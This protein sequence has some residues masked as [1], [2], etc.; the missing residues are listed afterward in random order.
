MSAIAT[1]AA[2]ARD[3]D[4]LI[5]DWRV[6]H[7]RLRKRLAGCEDW[8]A[9]DGTASTRLMLD[10]TGN[11]EEHALA[12]PD[13][14]Y[15][16]LALRAFDA[17]SGLWSIWWLDARHPDRLDPPVVGR[18]ENTTGTFYGDDVFEA[19]PIRVRFLWR[20]HAADAPHWEQAFSVDDGA[21][22]EINWT[23]DFVRSCG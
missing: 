3:F 10:G 11:V 5:G 17:A 22:W 14:A 15:R 16:A 12:L 4:F 9:F 18:F 13:G 8:E 7:R 6:R 23:M 20:I 2:G 19:R 1:T 21:S